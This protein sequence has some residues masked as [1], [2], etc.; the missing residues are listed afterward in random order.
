MYL[1][2]SSWLVLAFA[3]SG[4]AFAFSPAAA[5]RAASRGVVSLRC[6]ASPSP[7]VSRRSLGAL[8]A[9]GAVSAIVL[10]SNESAFAAEGQTK[11]KISAQGPAQALDMIIVMKVCPL[12]LNFVIRGCSSER[13]SSVDL[14]HAVITHTASRQAAKAYRE[15]GVDVEKGNFKPVDNWLSNTWSSSTGAFIKKNKASH[16]LLSHPF[17][18]SITF[19]SMPRHN[20]SRGPACD[21]LIIGAQV[22]ESLSTSVKGTSAG[23]DL[24]SDPAFYNEPSPE[25]KQVCRPKSAACSH[26]QRSLLF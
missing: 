9:A 1:K 25:S 6:S 13:G 22:L 10:R 12:S 20:I 4:D 8:V 21:F 23:Q 17:H 15:L 16:T 14:G 7:N 19:T 26:P 18:Q 3:A 24:E 5:P 2:I 11:K